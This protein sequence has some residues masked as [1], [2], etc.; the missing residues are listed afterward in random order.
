MDIKWTGLTQEILAEALEQARVGRLYIMDK[1][2]Q[3]ITTPKVQMSPHA[4]KMIRLKINPE[5]I[6]ALIGPGGRVIR[7]IQEETGTSIDVQDDGTVTIG[8]MDQ[9]MLEMASPRSTA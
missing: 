2:A 9:T 3:V 5:K 8:G 7:G 6:G 1:M 4:P